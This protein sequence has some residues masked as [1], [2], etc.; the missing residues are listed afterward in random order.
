MKKLLKKKTIILRTPVLLMRDCDTKNPHTCD[1]RKK[2]SGCKICRE[3]RLLI[4]SVKRF[5]H[6]C[7]LIDN[8]F[9]LT[10]FTFMTFSDWL[11]NNSQQIVRFSGGSFPAHNV[12][13]NV[14][15]V[16]SACFHVRLCVPWHWRLNSTHIGES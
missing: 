3:A 5:K 7:L 1:R 2:L 11:E 9:Q 8:M 14:L 6:N 4:Y 12:D 10:I 16:H 13:P 15:D